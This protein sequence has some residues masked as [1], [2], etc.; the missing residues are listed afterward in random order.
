MAEALELKVFALTKTF[1]L[2]ERFRS[3]DQLCRSS[4]S[5][6][7]NIAESYYK[8]SIK[9]KLRIVNDIAKSEAEETKR[10]LV[11]CFKKGFHKNILIVDEYTELIKAMSGYV[12]FLRAS[13]FV[14]V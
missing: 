7:N 5:V 9:E 14:V 13:N 12:R 3:V 10:N 6:T 2:D 1:P 8:R 4:A 11:V